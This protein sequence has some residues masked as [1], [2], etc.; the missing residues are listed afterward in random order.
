MLVTSK[1]L[2]A[3]AKKKHFAIPHFN[4]WSRASLLAYLDVA[5]ELKLPVILACAES[6]SSYMTTEEA[7][8][9]GLY[10]AKKADIPVVLHLDHGV[11]LSNIQYAVD[12]GFT[13]VMIDAS[14]ETFANN[15]KK[16]KEVVEYAHNKGVVVEAELGHVGSATNYD[17]NDDSNYTQ[18]E[19]AVEFVNQTNVDS[20]A[21]AIGTAHGT[22]KGAPHINFDRLKEL[23]AH[24]PV[25]LVLHGG[26]SSGDDNLSKATE[27]GICKI[28]IFTDIT[29]AALQN[30]REKEYQNYIQLEKDAY[31]G[32][33]EMA[34]HYYHVFHTKR[35]NEK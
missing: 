13:S 4:F 21:V 28:N 15:V 19:A 35:Y 10:Y 7:A 33:K 23:S 24:V 29:I 8:E 30:T 34:K 31:L 6:H 2:L 11:N 12:N 20:L 16:T 26:S 9:F 1:E 25:P 17:I 14:Q 5:Q 27:L 3:I 32:M 18:V 22:Y